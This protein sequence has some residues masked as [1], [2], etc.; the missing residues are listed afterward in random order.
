[1]I[2]QGIVISFSY[3]CFVW[4]HILD[5]QVRVYVGTC[6]TVIMCITKSST[7]NLNPSSNQQF[8]FIPPNSNIIFNKSNQ[9]EDIQV[10]FVSQFMRSMSLST[11]CVPSFGKCHQF[12][13]N[14]IPSFNKSF[15]TNMLMSLA[16]LYRG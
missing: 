8:N 11:L 12:E 15:P 9:P 10:P 14:S 16:I 7:Q 13:P 6:R 3:F 1:M 5:I 2:S 4:I